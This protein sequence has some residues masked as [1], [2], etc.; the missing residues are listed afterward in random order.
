MVFNA[1]SS[2]LLGGDVTATFIMAAL[3]AL[4][5]LLMMF[6]LRQESGEATPRHAPHFRSAVSHSHI[7]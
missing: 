5:P 6:L 4:V 1:V 7:A 3:S 2:H